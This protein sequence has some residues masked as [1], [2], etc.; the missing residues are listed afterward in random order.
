VPER[1]SVA[2]DGLFIASAVLDA[3]AGQL[4]SADG[5]F[6]V[7]AKASSEG[8]ASVHAAIAAFNMAYGARLANRGQSAAEAATRY[9][10][11]DDDAADDIGDVSV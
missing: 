9:A 4:V 3:H 7:G 6:P 10:A 1:L 5:A 2:A 8:A 11:V